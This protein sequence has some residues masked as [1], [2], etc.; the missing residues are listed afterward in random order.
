MILTRSEKTSKPINKKYDKVMKFE[1]IEQ[2]TTDLVEER[3]KNSEMLTKY[4]AVAAEN[5]TLKNKL[6]TMGEDM[7]KLKNSVKLAFEEEEQTK[8]NIRELVTAMQGQLNAAQ[9]RVLEKEKENLELLELLQKFK[10]LGLLQKFA[11]AQRSQKQEVEEEIERLVEEE[12]EDEQMEEPDNDYGMYGGMMSKLAGRE[13]MQTSSVNHHT[14][15]DKRPCNTDDDDLESDF[16]SSKVLAKKLASTTK[17][18]SKIKA[19][20]IAKTNSLQESGHLKQTSSKAKLGPAKSDK[21]TQ[22]SK[23]ELA[24]SKQHKPS[25]QGN[26]AA[27]ASKALSSIK[28]TK[29]T[30]QK[31]QSSSAQNEPFSQDSAA[32]KKT[33]ETKVHKKAKTKEQ[34]GRLSK[35]ERSEMLSKME[36]M[37]EMASVLKSFESR[38]KQMQTDMG[39][40]AAK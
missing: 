24:P 1:Q 28:K 26:K 22:E 18:K 29:E 23:D 25:Q 4:N 21:H 11:E 16:Q 33:M 13:S 35:E 10:D 19:N 2:I 9:Q 17:Q 30:I 27:L 5:E 34:E 36:M 12:E 38:I 15:S 31:I 37:S 39:R 7:T 6:I 40:L 14:I 3:K 32:G 20:D 8:Q